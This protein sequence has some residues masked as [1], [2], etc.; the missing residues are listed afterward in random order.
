ML[1]GSSETAGAGVN[2]ETVVAGSSVDSQVPGGDALIRFTEAVI[3][4]SADL[5]EARDA[6]VGELGETRMVDAAGVV[7]NFERMVRIADSTGI[8]VDGA[9]AESMRE[10]RES[11]GLNELPSARLQS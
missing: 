11:L 2:L 3:G 10:V 4:N 9:M 6:L 5:T 7:G 8:P 1:R